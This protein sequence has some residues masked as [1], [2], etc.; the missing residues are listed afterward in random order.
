MEK[1]KKKNDNKLDNEDWEVLEKTEVGEDDVISSDSQKS[2][3][4]DLAEM[5][6][7]I[8][9][10]TCFWTS[11]LFGNLDTGV[12]PTTLHQMMEELGTT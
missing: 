11:G 3:Q 9:I 7:R 2:E 1:G 5:S 4:M 10:Y 12:I 6:I 8:G